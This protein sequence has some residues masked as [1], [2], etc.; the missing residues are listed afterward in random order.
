MVFATTQYGNTTA[1]RTDYILSGLGSHDDASRHVGDAARR[2]H[3]KQG[4]HDDSRER[5]K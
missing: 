4:R 1:S 2:D 3:R 5:S